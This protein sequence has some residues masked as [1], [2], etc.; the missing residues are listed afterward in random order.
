MNVL[1]DPNVAYVLLILG[2]LTAV[3]ALFSPGTGVLEIVALFALAIAG[4]EI[5]NLNINLWALALMGVGIVPFVAA[6]RAPRNAR[7]PLIA[8]AALAFVIGSTFLFR[9][10]SWLPVVSPVLVLLLAPLAI[11]GTWW[12][13]TKS[14]EAVT[15]RPVFDLDRL[16]GMSG[17]ASSDIRG[18]GTVYVNGEEW[19]ALSKS[20]IPA[21]S[22]IRVVRRKGLALEVEV[23][24]Q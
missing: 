18:Q 7:P 2:F 13:T 23:L 12:L 3:L 9:G 1:I 17:Q 8:A 6:L 21:G 14:I 11:G 24:H 15:T 16:I 20:F 4:Y 5:V 22:P 10:E 19:T